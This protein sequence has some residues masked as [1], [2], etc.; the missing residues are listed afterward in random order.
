MLAPASVVQEVRECIVNLIL[1]QGASYSIHG[2]KFFRGKIAKVT[3]DE[4]ARYLLS[5]DKFIE[6]DDEPEV[7]N[8]PAAPPKV[9]VP[10]A[11]AK[12]IQLVKK[13]RTPAPVPVPAGKSGEP[14]DPAVDV[15]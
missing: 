5:T 4:M 10:S 1:T 12:G 8:V 7:E 13:S 15:T 9:A 14:S 11:P 6:T 3:D 2:T